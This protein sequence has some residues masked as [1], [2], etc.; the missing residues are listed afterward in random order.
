M[1]KVKKT[2]FIDRFKNA[3]KAF[4]GKP[5]GSVQF[6]VDVKRC[7]QCEYKNE[8]PIRDNLLVTAGARAAYMQGTMNKVGD[9]IE[10]DERTNEWLKEHPWPTTV[11]QCEKCG[12]WYKYDLGH[13]C[14][15]EEK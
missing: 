12:L 11:V 10:C 8:N 5:I 14:K 9:R 7:D 1:N 15:G 13:E 3:V 4:K 2:T 6:G